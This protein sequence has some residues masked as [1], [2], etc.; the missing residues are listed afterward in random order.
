MNGNKLF[1]VYFCDNKI[2][3]VTHPRGLCVPAPAAA[4]FN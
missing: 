1:F 3:L 2:I 4:N